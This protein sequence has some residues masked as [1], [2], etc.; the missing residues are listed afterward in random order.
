MCN[1]YGFN[2]KEKDSNGE[3][4]N[5]HYDY[6]FRIYNPSIGRFL[7]VD[8]MTKYYPAWSPYPFAMN[9][10]IDG[11]D[12][13]GLEWEKATDDQG[14]TSVS[15]NTNFSADQELGLTSEQI[16]AYQNAIGS[17]LNSTLQSSSGGTVS[18]S[19]TFNGGDGNGR[20]VP[21]VNLYGAK[22]TGGPNDPMIAGSNSFEHISLNIYNKDGSVKSPAQLAEDVVHELL[23]TLRF[24]HPFEK[25][26]G[27]DTKLIH[28]GGNNYSTTPTTDPNILYNIM[29]YSLISIDGKN[30][31]ELW[32]SNGP[33]PTLITKDQINL[34]MNEINLQMQGYGV[35]PK[36]DSNLSNKQNEEN[37]IKYFLDYW[38]NTPGQDVEKKK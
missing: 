27:P 9:R 36:Y 38:S 13:D 1:R 5:T 4:G 17:Q 8:P 35:A 28:Q 11:I 33:S 3:F 30:L 12:K 22:H 7:S 19:V 31:G 34:M 16:G 29:N 37:Y 21:T 26:Q 23:H 32:K 20:V 6:G 18:G 24:E 10:P 14:N 2:G 25:T 15:V